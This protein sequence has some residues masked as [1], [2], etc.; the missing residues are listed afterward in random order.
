LLPDRPPLMAAITLTDRAG[1]ALTPME[2]LNDNRFVTRFD[3]LRHYRTANVRQ[4]A[5]HAFNAPVVNNMDLIHGFLLMGNRFSG[6]LFPC[7]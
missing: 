7:H 2:A 6:V 1:H 5:R 3:K 4:Q